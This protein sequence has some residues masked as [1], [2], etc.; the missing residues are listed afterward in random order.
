MALPLAHVLPPRW[1]SPRWGSWQFAINLDDLSP[2]RGRPYTSLGQPGQQPPNRPRR[3]AG[4]PQHVAH[5]SGLSTPYRF[6]LGRRGNRGCCAGSLH[7]DGGGGIGITQRAFE[8]VAL[9]Q[10]RR[11]G[12][13]ES[14]SSGGGVHGPNAMSR[15]VHLLF[16]EYGERTERAEGR[17]DDLLRSSPQAPT[18]GTQLRKT[19]GPA[20]ERAFLYAGALRSRLPPRTMVVKKI[21][22][23]V[24]RCCLTI[25]VNRRERRQSAP[26]LRRP[27]PAASARPQDEDKR[28]A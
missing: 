27:Q 6:D 3:A 4:R 23:E 26:S 28:Q 25:G 12:P 8:R 9:R 5:Y 7:A 19:H 22:I 14:I 21:I 20:G 1:G 17:D 10:T 24:E 16:A 15:D 11:G 13:G 2:E 18:G